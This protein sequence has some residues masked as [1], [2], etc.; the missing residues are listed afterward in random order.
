MAYRALATHRWHARR[1]LE[2]AG[3]D[4]NEDSLMRLVTTGLSP[5]EQSGGT[6]EFQLTCPRQNTGRTKTV[7]PHRLV[8][9]V[10]HDHLPKKPDGRGR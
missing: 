2:F 1:G 9:G 4:P 5:V 10:L 7:I 3:L 8:A 6:G